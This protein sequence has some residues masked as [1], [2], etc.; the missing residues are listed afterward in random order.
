MGRPA[1]LDSRTV[2]PR[3][4]A[5]REARDAVRRMEAEIFGRRGEGRIEPSN[6]RMLQLLE[7]LGEPQKSYRSIHLTGTNGK[8]ST[9]RM[10]DELL[11]ALGPRTGRYTSPHLTRVN[12]RIVLDGEPVPDEV[13]AAAYDEL[14]PYVE[15]VDSRNDIPLSFFEIM[16]A[17]AFAIFA[18]APVEIAVVE[19][20][21]GGTWDNTN[22]IDGD[23]AVIT[24]IALDHM[25][26][27]GPDIR[28]IA[29]EK[30]G[31][32]KVLKLNVGGLTLT[33]PEISAYVLL[34]LKKN[35][36][37]FFGEPVTKAVITVPANR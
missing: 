24:P 3:N 1:S 31:T 12:E 11:R 30:A 17:L 21:L 9:A 14:K 22:T 34:Q 16:T 6:K 28:S 27:L 5:E 37:R 10:V 20:G 29:T 19:V 4:D 33:P 8:T 13:L 36:E 18:D 25:E 23:V 35:A 15:L 26:Y 7:V 2:N 32:L